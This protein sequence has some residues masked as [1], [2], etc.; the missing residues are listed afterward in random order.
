[1][2]NAAD[3]STCDA[4]GNLTAL[5][6][7]GI[8]QGDEETIGH[9]H[10]VETCGTVDG[11]GLRYVL[12]LSGCPLRC[13]YCHNPDAQGKPRGNTKT[14]GEV[15]RDVLRYRSF[16]RDGG[17][18]VSGGEPLLQADFVAALFAGAN[19]SGLHTT[20]DTSGFRGDVV[21]SLLLDHTDL[22]LLDIKSWEPA[23]YKHVTGVPIDSTLAFAR[24]LEQRGIPVW[25]R[26]VLVPGLTDD[27][28][29]ID[30][31]ARFV[32]TL[33]NVQRVQLLPFHKLARHKYAQ[34]GRRFQLD[35][36][37]TPT[38]EQIARAREI[39]AQNGVTVD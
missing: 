19:Q 11:P 10:S 31:L 30:G 7:A 29:N 23:T 13:M 16:I 33:T 34:L 17:L 2:E 3:S 39:F 12:F 5:S 14:V 1:M 18:T 20:L 35:A 26:F 6:G 21:P 36:T 27:D 37:P 38:P 4:C 32:A 28:A 8:Q 9:I 24:R 25:V 15:L 22:V